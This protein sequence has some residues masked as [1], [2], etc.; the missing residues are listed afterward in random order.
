MK[1]FFIIGNPRSGTT[2]FRL[3]LNKHA[4][5]SVP[6]EAGFLV[7][8]H[9]EF[10]KGIIGNKYTSL[11]DFLQNTKKIES[12]KL[13]YKLLEEYLNIQQ[14]QNYSDV[15]DV[16]YE[17]YSRT[18]LNKK[19]SLYGDKNNYYLKHID[20]LHKLYPNAKFI[21]IIRDGRSVAASYQE[22]MKKD[23][24]F[25]YAPDLPTNLIDIADEWGD[26]IKL[27]EDEFYKLPGNLTYLVKY[28]ELVLEPENNL[29][30]ICNFLKLDYDENMLDYYKT[31]EEEGL[32]PKE[33]L[34]WKSK[35]LKP[36]IK[37]DIYKFRLLSKEDRGEFELLTRGSLQKYGYI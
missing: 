1:R 21:H 10:G 19:V 31:S 6:P 27:I 24:S 3:M 16:V 12:W 34:N 22:L 9:Q 33:Y 36:L 17:F 32:E 18:I 37:D 35:S 20:L 26:N 11:V 25:K 28:E 29:R 8:M 13:N 23:F 15:M 4:E 7:W 5:V 2:L 14:P 30:N